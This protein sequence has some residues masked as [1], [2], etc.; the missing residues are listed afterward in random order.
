MSDELRRQDFKIKTPFLV[1]YGTIV[2]KDDKWI[3]E[4]IDRRIYSLKGITAQKLKDKCE[5][6]GWKLERRGNGK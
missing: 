6:W 1:A 3:V 2:K 5:R 4:S